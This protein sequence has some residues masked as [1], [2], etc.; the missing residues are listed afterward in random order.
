[1][2]EFQRNLGFCSQCDR[3]L[4]IGHYFG[5]GRSADSIR[6]LFVSVFGGF[7]GLFFDFSGE[8]MVLPQFILY[9]LWLVLCMLHRA[10][11][12]ACL[13]GVSVWGDP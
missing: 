11:S 9:K 8:I 7:L 6:T 2:E 3:K 1:M 12:L 13:G 10:R 4:V 5:N